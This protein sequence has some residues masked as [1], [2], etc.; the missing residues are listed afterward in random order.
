MVGF[1]GIVTHNSFPFIRWSQSWTRRTHRRSSVGIYRLP[2]PRTGGVATYNVYLYLR[3]HVKIRQRYWETRRANWQRDGL[4]ITIT[5]RR[6]YC[7]THRASELG[8]WARRQRKCRGRCRT[9]GVTLG[10][11][12][13]LSTQARHWRGGMV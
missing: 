10:L 4:Q 6:K 7:H 3:S 1:N 8:A 5:R 11:A 13:D 2:V 12:T 9:V